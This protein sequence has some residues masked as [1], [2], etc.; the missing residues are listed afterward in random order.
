MKN[1][2]TKIVLFII[3]TLLSFGCSLTKNLDSRSLILKSNKI[4][5]NDKKSTIDSL[6]PLIVQKK[7]SYILGFPIS[8]KLY[9]SSEENSDS[10]FELWLYKR[11]K[12]EKKLNSLLSAKQ[13]NQIKK[14]KNDFN[15][16]KKRNG[17]KLEILDSTKTSISIE[18]LKSYFNNNG[19]FNSHVTSSININQTN[20]KYA[21]LVY[22]VT[23]GNQYLLDSIKTNIKSKKLDSIY[24]LN[25]EKSFLKYNDP[26]N[27]R[28]FE[29]ERNRIDKLFKNNGIYDFQINAISFKISLDTI[30]LSSRIPVEINIEEKENGKYDTNRIKEVNVYI[31]N[32]DINL[33]FKKNIFYNGVN[34]YSNDSFYYKPEILY[35]LIYIKKNDLYSDELRN[36]TIN[37][38][39][40]FDNF[41]YPSIDYNYLGESKNELEASIT[42][43]PQKKYSLGFGLDLKHSN[44]E[45]VGIAFEASILNRN[46]FKGGEKLEFATRGTIGK[47]G[48][49]TI[50][51]YGFDFRLRFPRLLAPKKLRDILELKNNPISFINLGTSNQN[52]IGLDRQNFRFN[53]NYKWNDNKNNTKNLNLINIELVNNKN[54]HNYFNIYSNSYKSIN[55]IAIFNSA[56]SNYFNSKNELIIPEGI[57]NYINDVISNPNL[58]SESDFK[59]LNYIN[60]K[61]KR[62]TANNLI[63]GS[64][65]SFL[66]SSRKNIFENQ[67]SEFKF[68]IEVAGNITNL[69]SNIFNVS[70]NEFGKNKILDLA[71][72]QFFK[73]ELGYIKHLQIGLNSKI[74]IRSFFGIAVPFGNSNNIPFSKSFFAGGSNDNRAWEVY[75]LGPGI[76]GATSEFNEANMKISVNV[77]YR[78]KILGKLDGAIFNDFGNIWNVFDDSNDSKRSFDGFK[79]LSE[80]AIGSGF[81]FRYNLGYFV[82]RLDTGFKT[83]NPVL[84][85]K[86]RW[87]TDFNFKKAVYNIGLNYPF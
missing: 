76:S 85:K 10:I 9:E 54:I 5:I 64:S 43:V 77:E 63:I 23:L 2:I 44:I 73:T 29:K 6:L 67:F 13:V 11:K 79:D 45:D 21:E 60:D 50:S 28:N 40:N 59:D 51:E 84:E 15:N 48:N 7:N 22:K 58:V 71:Y 37:S 78:F 27:T 19:Y 56:P 8:A 12:R 69:I 53:F 41:Q 26:F 25:N 82:L 74:A 38:L 3:L 49:T 20:N 80:I 36:K 35:D 52:N 14:Y 75:R 24:K 70:K 34:F 87:L 57:D 65:Y 17:E 46:F 81:G 16:W 72:S 32:N 33:K 42:L 83:Y 39:N 68:K 61:R 86:K 30:S 1:I 66:N 62:L 31:K 4:Y 18:N 47:S 55:K